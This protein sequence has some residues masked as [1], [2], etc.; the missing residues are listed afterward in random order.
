[1]S[2]EAR[3]LSFE[4]IAKSFGGIEAIRPLSLDVKA[5]E[6]LTLLGP[7][8]SGK[9]TLL[10]IA[11]GFVIPDAGRLRI[12]ADDVTALSPRK[13]DIGMV[14]QNYALFPHMTVFENVAYGLRVR[15]QPRHE[16]E[17]RVKDALGMARLDGHEDRAI[18]QLSG[19]QQQRVALARALVIEPA[20][21]LMDEPL[22][23][24]DRQLRK[25]V[26]LEIRRLHREL[27]RTTL[28]VTH[29]Q[30]EALVMSDRIAVMRD[31]N[32]EQVGT[33]AELYRQPA[34]VFVAS[35][36][37]ESNILT[38]RVTQLAN[39]SARVALSEHQI[40]VVGEGAMGLSVGMDA[41]V[42]IRPEALALSEA[43]AG[44]PARV[45]ELVYLGDIVAIR[46]KLPHGSELWCRRFSS[47]DMPEEGRDVRLSWR[48]QD[49]RI[50]PMLSSP[51]EAD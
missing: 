32:I 42:L 15:G 21:L 7:S 46:L 4:G 24:L 13:R 33:P 16:I 43:G 20:V 31:G 39:G 14:F 22:G 47:A 44:L 36:L 37:G 41:G 40:E 26:Q 1:M 49:V 30:E 35:F 29:D 9:T 50:I 17:R 48:D 6:F 19:G 8:G 2:T 12:G 5:G 11:A 28:N 25:H 10:N 23:A 51:R 3:S 45:V 27:R 18:G 34:N 38:G